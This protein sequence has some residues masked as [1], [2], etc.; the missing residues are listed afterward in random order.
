M[1]SRTCS[2]SVS[3]RSKFI[4]IAK[5]F[6]IGVV[7][8]LPRFSR[9]KAAVVLPASPCTLSWNLSQDVSVVGYALYYGI[10]GSTT[11]NRQALG[12]TNAVTL[13]NLL[14]SSNYFFYIVA[15]NAAGVESPPSNVLYYNAQAI[16]SLKLTSP[17]QGTMNLQLRTAPGSVCIVEYTPSLNPA[18]W[19]NLCSATADSNGNIAVTDQPSPNIPSRFYRAVLYSSPQVLSAMAINCST[20]GTITLQF[21]AASGT[22]CRVQFTPSLNPPQWQTL[23]SATADSNGNVTMT[24]QVSANTTGRFYRAVTP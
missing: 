12:L 8:V 23:G 1:K 20:A 16:S 24:D 17:A 14:A 5:I 11:T 18:Q 21:H 19:Q 9:L 22:A 13:F 6:L 4:S 2:L 10:N 7:L 15:C 3:F